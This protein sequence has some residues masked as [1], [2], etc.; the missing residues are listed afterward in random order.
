MSRRPLWSTIQ[1]ARLTILASRS[2]RP[3]Q[4]VAYACKN[5]TLFTIHFTLD[6]KS[7]VMRIDTKKI[8][9]EMTQFQASSVTPDSRTATIPKLK[10]VHQHS[11]A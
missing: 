1:V 2:C 3:S 6:E 5:W 4:I 11:L 8:V 7:F 10:I 9:T